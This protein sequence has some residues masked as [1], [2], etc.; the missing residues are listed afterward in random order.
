MLNKTGANNADVI[1]IGGGLHGCS[2]ALHLALAGTSV[3]LLE[4]DYVGRHASGVNAGGVRRLGRHQAEIP[5]SVASAEIWRTIESLVDDDCG[6]TPSAQISVA[7]SEAD[8]QRI[9]KRL[10]LLTQ[11]G[12][13]HEKE[14]D[15]QTLREQMPKV[16]PHC[17]GGLIVEGDGHANPFRTV[18]A[19]RRKCEQLGVRI[20]ESCRVEKITRHGNI[21]QIR[22]NGQMYES[23]VLVNCAGAWGGKIAGML[24]EKIPVVARAPM[25]MISARM[26][27]FINPVVGAQ[28]RTLSFKQFANGSVLIGG[29]FEGSA[30]PE[31][32]HTQLD[33]TGLMTNARTAVDI[34][35]IMRKASIVRCWAGIEGIMPDKIP[36]IGQSQC[37]AAF[38][39]FG[40][41]A[42]GFQLGP[43]G[44]RILSELVID[45]ATDLPIEAFR[46]D[47][48]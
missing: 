9:K 10:A 4:K 3:I 12:F 39:S 38:H 28:G 16:S 14:I 47:R 6:F 34:F 11:L 1:V 36:V 2:T 20:R 8:L 22:A 23:P 35:P 18:Q 46:S 15:Q 7:E 32:N 44:G 30:N 17:L 25:L 24:G 40:F 37:E 31:T 43:V 45:G 48:F 5:L 13:D 27:P 33:Y 26:P 21:W 19:F 41:S 42:H 29:G